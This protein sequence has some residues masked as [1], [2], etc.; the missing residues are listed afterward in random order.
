MSS[1]RPNLVPVTPKM[2]GRGMPLPPRIL[3][4]SVIV[5][6]VAFAVGLQVN[7]TQTLPAPSARPSVIAL[8]STPLATVAPVDTSV[9]P[10]TQL[11]VGIYHLTQP[12]A[13]EIAIASRF[14]AAYNAGQLTTVMA[15][16]SSSPQ[17]LDCNYATDRALTITGRSAVETYLRTRFAEHDRW[18][19]EFYQENPD[20]RNEVVVLPLERSNDTLR[21]LGAPGGVKNTFPEDFALFFNAD[22]TALDTIAWNTMPGSVGGGSVGDLCSP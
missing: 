22:G 9:V 3:T 17:F 7:P 2:S 11:P 20:N 5:A 18:T 19:V 15:L 12:V 1:E 14:Y 6:L 8:P 21:R 13:N 10:S 4:V 16:L